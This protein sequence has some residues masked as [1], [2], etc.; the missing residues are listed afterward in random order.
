M[1]NIL[2]HL[3]QNLQE[4]YRQAIDVDN[5]IGQLKQ[6]GM[7]KFASVFP[8]KNLFNCNDKIVMPYVEELAEDI[9][10]FRAS[11]D[12]NLLNT[13]LKKMEMLHKVLGAFKNLTKSN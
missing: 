8:T 6:Q 9:V 11:Q 13:I 12:Q 7:A 1:K 5:Q 3:D 4:I 10:M 2:P